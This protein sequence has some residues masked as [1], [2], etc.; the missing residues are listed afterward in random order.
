MKLV[1]RQ[2]RCPQIQG[3]RRAADAG[4]LTQYDEEATPA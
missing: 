2:R 4:V 3:A 1:A